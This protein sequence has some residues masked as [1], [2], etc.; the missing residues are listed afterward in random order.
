MDWFQHMA[1]VYPP[2]AYSY[3][4]DLLNF[5]LVKNDWLSLDPLTPDSK[6]RDFLQ[7]PENSRMKLLWSRFEPEVDI[8]IPL[9]VMWNRRSNTYIYWETANLRLVL[10][11]QEFLKTFDRFKFV[12]EELPDGEKQGRYSVPLGFL[13][14]ATRPTYV[15]RRFTEGTRAAEFAQALRL[16]SIASVME[17]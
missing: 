14:V 12:L 10:T 11:L 17:A 4:G 5:E 15:N 2:G 9:Y 3:V 1:G 8:P 13:Y 6:F 16:V 7:R